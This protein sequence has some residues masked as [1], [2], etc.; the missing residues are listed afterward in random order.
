MTS[1]ESQRQNMIQNLEPSAI[2]SLYDDEEVCA[3]I[4]CELMKS[5]QFIPRP[6]LIY[7]DYD[8]YST[9]FRNYIYEFLYDGKDAEYTLGKIIDIVKIYSMSVDLSN[10]KEGFIILMITIVLMLIMLSSLALLFMKKYAH[11]F[12][13]FNI[14]GWTILFMGYIINLSNIFTQYGEIT[15]SKCHTRIILNSFGFT[16][17]TVPVLYKLVANFHEKKGIII[18]IEKD[19]YRFFLL[20]SLFDIFMSLL[21]FIPAYDVETID[22][23][24]GRNYQLCSINNFG[25]VVQSFIFLE[26]LFIALCISAMVFLEWSVVKLKKDI[27]LITYSLYVNA[28]IAVIL[29]IFKF[30]TINNYKAHFTIYSSIILLSV[31]SCYFFMYGLRIILLIIKKDKP[32][33]KYIQ[34]AETV[35]TANSKTS[36]TS[37][38]ITF[39]QNSNSGSMTLKILQ[40]HYYTGEEDKERGEMTVPSMTEPSLSVTCNSIN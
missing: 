23:K 29:V 36:K 21:S 38:S 22:I 37:K 19:K 2:M 39:S 40:H 6:S 5:L 17:M 15:Q 24:D 14:D 20:F 13:F 9:R 11:L 1:R 28:L 26:K 35:L 3:V 4:D 8:D 10:S 12:S 25:K 7:K 16:F 31:F 33:L 32:K 18:W 34:K 27:K 30:L